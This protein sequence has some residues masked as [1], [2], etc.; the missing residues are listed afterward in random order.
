MANTTFE[1]IDK[2]NVVLLVVDHQIGLAQLVR[3]FDA[4]Q[5]RNNVLAHAAIGKVFNL[6][7]ILTTSA[8]TGQSLSDRHLLLLRLNLLLQG[9]MD[10]FPKRSLT[11]TQMLR[12]SNARARSTLGTIATSARPSRL[13]ERSRSSWLVLSQTYVHRSDTSCIYIHFTRAYRSAL[14]SLHFPLPKK[15]TPSMLM[16]TPPVPCPNRLQRT[17]TIGCALLVFRSSLLSRWFATL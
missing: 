11:C 9:L 6:P 3:D 13:Q 5:F 8:E 17:R 7:T 14:R 12:I 2:D 1:R 16:L 15:D 10:L 4:D